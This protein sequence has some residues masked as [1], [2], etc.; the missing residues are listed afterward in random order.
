MQIDKEELYCDAE[1]DNDDDDNDDEDDDNDD[2]DHDGDG[3]GYS[4]V[5]DHMVAN[6][7]RETTALKLVVVYVSEIQNWRRC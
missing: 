4:L 2:D 1:D 6:E 3:G 5:G 7:H